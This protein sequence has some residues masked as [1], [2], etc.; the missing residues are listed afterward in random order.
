[1]RIPRQF[2]SVAVKKVSAIALKNGRWDGSGPITFSSGQKFVRN[3][4]QK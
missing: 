3:C 2:V 1:M 4:A